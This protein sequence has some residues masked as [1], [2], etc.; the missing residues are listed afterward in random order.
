MDRFRRLYGASPLHLAGTLAA[1]AV[2][3]VAARQ[4]LGDRPVAVLVWL[5]G[6]ALV[7]DL[8]LAPLYLALDRAGRGAGARPW[9]WGHVRFPAA[10]SLLLLLV[11]APEIT[12]RSEGTFRAATGLDQ[13][14]YLGRWL[15]LTGALFALSAVLLLVR[16]V[17]WRRSHQA[18]TGRATPGATSRA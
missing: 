18:G 8:V 15:A 2:A 4:L 1:L 11:W 3:G 14:G 6:A 16:L 10:L 17:R 12:R 13:S 7:H 9:W 5:V